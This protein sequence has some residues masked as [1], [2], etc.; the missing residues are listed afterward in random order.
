MYIYRLLSALNKFHSFIHSFIHSLGPCYED[1]W[2]SGDAWEYSQLWLVSC[3]RCDPCETCPI[4]EC[5]RRITHHC[6][7]TINAFLSDIAG[8]AGTLS[9]NDAWLT[10][11]TRI[12]LR[13]TALSIITSV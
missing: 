3:S 5:F 10:D 6:V 8:N 11:S 9:R 4:Y 1:C 7:S 12:K 13:L 2:Q